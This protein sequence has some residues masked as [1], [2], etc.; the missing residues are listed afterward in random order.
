MQLPLTLQGRRK[1]EARKANAELGGENL[2]IRKTSIISHFPWDLLDA[3]WKLN[4]AGPGAGTSELDSRCGDNFGR[5]YHLLH[6]Q[7]RKCATRVNQGQAQR[8]T[9]LLQLE[10]LLSPTTLSLESVPGK[11][12]SASP[13]RK[14]ARPRPT[15]LCGRGQQYSH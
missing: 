4:S 10:P 9:L 5:I 7:P 8:P 14:H 11:G 1:T 6:P 13:Q 12:S 3:S 15:P 2:H